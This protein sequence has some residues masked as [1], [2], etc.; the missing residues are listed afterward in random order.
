VEVGKVNEESKGGRIWWM[1]FV[2]MYG[3]STMKP[4]EIILRREEGDMGE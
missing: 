2:Y 4:V 3:N 1:H